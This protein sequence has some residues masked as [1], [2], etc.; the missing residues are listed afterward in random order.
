MYER[1]EYEQGGQFLKKERPPRFQSKY[2]YNIWHAESWNFKILQSCKI[3]K[4]Q[5][6]TLME[7]LEISR[8]VMQNLEISIFSMQNI[9]ISIF[10]V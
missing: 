6:V 2:N 8:F 5:D 9:E 4:F 10:G 3:L 7:N 1:F